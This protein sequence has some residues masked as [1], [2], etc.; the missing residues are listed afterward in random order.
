MSDDRINDMLNGFQF[1]REATHPYYREAE[2]L[3]AEDAADDDRRLTEV[4]RAF[5]KSLGP[6]APS[7][8]E[9]DYK[10]MIMAGIDPEYDASGNVLMP[11][12]FYKAG[13]QPAESLPTEARIMQGAASIAG[14]VAH[15]V[16]QGAI[17]TGEFL[18]KAGNQMAGQV[19]PL[20]RIGQ[21]DRE[22]RIDSSMDNV[23]NPI[24]KP[25]S[26]AGGLISGIAQFM[27]IGGPVAGVMKK[28][29]AGAVKRGL[30]SGAS[31]DVA[32]FDPEDGNLSNMLVEI[33]EEN[34]DHAGLN[35][36]FIRWLSVDDNDSDFEGRLKAALEG[37]GIGLAFEG[38]LKA[39]VSMKQAR[40]ASQ[41]AEAAE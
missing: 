20:A 6:S 21:A 11:A 32:A 10:R 29:G 9:F 36:E 38:V 19:N 27:S 17:E 22:Q 12:M 7:M 3:K 28:A 1:R 34:P 31:A 16:A 5:H 40:K 4:A 35:N 26:L 39:A 13:A 33:G 23:E 37:A 18:A 25:D 30:V 24:D 15:G 14:D 41:V 8:A 2:E